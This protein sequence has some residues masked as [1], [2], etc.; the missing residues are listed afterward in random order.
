M[1]LLKG[2]ITL[3][4]YPGND[5]NE[6]TKKFAAAYIARWGEDAETHVANA[7]DLM[8][9]FFM[10]AEKANPLTPENV[11]AEMHKVM[12]LSGASG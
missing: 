12:R 10:A 5:A 8:Q 11:A 2:F 3:L 7:Y 9:V 6:Q 4:P 1:R